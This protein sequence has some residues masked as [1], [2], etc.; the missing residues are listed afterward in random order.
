L[1]AASPQSW[2]F[3]ER[4]L[5]MA[6]I[7]PQSQTGKELSPFRHRLVHIVAGQFP[8]SYPTNFNL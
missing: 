1:S 3:H 2:N 8:G 5:A 7:C 4:E 6:T